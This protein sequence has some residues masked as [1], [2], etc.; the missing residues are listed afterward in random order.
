MRR[1]PAGA[2]CA[3]AA[4]LAACGEEERP[5]SPRL[6]DP[7]KKPLVNSLAVDPSDRALLLTTNKGFFR[8]EQGSR[9][10]KR[11][12]GMVRSGRRSAKV[13]TFLEL[14]YAGPRLLLGSGHP[15]RSRGRRGS[16]L[17]EFLGLMRSHDGGRSWRTVS[18]VGLADLHVI[19]M[20]RGRLYALDVVLGGLL[21]SRD[22][23]R[24]WKERTTPR[25]TIL[26]VVVDPDDPRHLVASSEDALFS[27]TDEGETW[28]PLGSGDSDRLAWPAPEALYRASKDGRVEV[29]DEGGE[30]WR[31]V[32]EL[33]GEPWA[34]TAVGARRLYAALSD[35]TIQQSRDGGETW[36]TRFRP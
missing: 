31:E 7:D 12:T 33:D 26:D 30:D 14:S 15:D 36:T 3:L 16:K 9:R 34:L 11:V 2:A 29:S 28:R 22:E 18:R 13:G 24:T 10:A 32:G 25:G 21:V 6:V 4:A 5:L 8:I 23:G 19:H 35:A 27:S 17:P 20:V 1:V